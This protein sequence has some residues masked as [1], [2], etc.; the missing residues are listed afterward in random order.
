MVGDGELLTNDSNA[1]II[2]LRI[3]T[4]FNDIL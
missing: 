1:D 4:D 3:E 2:E